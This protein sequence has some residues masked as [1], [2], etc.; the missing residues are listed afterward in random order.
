MFVR[1][2]KGTVT[3]TG[4]VDHR[5]EAE[6]AEREL[7]QLSGVVAVENWISIKSLSR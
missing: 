5:F 4:E 7:K 6:V 1:V 2:S 3:L